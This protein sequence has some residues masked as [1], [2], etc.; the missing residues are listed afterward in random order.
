MPARAFRHTI[1]LSPRFPLAL[2]LG[3]RS[4]GLTISSAT[5]RSLLG[6]VI[7]AGA[8]TGLALTNPDRADFQRFAG[9]RLTELIRKEFCRDDGLPMMLRLLIHDC[10]GLVA[11]Q[12]SVFG[13]LALAHTVRRNFGIFSLYT[14]ELGG[15]ELLPNLRLPRYRAVTL[16]GAGQFL[17]LR[18]ETSDDR[19]DQP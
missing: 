16:A 14:T 2:W 11:S 4:S 8:T 17:M 15:Q 18:S 1:G 13:R 9:D 6:I 12:N 5:S 7:A 19:F 10:D 3:N